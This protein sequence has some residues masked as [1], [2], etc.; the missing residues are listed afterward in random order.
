MIGMRP[1]S[2]KL[3]GY[4]ELGIKAGTAHSAVRGFN[5]RVWLAVADVISR[6]T[7]GRRHGFSRICSDGQTRCGT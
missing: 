3:A 4:G 1:K 7:V 5:F 2:D 6:A